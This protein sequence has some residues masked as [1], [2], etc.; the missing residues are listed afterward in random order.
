MF[1]T[2]IQRYQIATQHTTTI[3]DVS[4]QE[5]YATGGDPV[6]QGTFHIRWTS[7]TYGSASRATI[8][9]DSDHHLH[10]TDGAFR[11]TQR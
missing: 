6:V 10:D 9:C 7:R 5:N 3:M 11:R 2:F 8:A 1:E 4:Q